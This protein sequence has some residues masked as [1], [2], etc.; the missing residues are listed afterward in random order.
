MV[1][2]APVIV[3]PR[4]FCPSAGMPYARSSLMQQLVIAVA[5]HGDYTG[6]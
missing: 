4:W 5:R 3:T 1:H 2:A 6:E